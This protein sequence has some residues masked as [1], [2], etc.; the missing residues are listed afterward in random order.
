MIPAPT[1]S[2]LDRH[3][4]LE[5]FFALDPP[6]DGGHYELIDGVL[7]MVPPPG[8]SHGLVVSRLNIVFAQYATRHPDRCLLLVPRAPVWTLA[9]TYLEPDLF[10]VTCERAV[11]VVEERLESAD[12]VVEVLSPS[13]AT[14]DRTAKADAYRTLDVRELW[15]VDM[16][17]QSVEQRV[18][19]ELGWRVAG[20]HRGEAPFEAAVFPEL[21]VVPSA[22]FGPL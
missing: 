7:Y 20:V 21:T 13:T 8:W 1:A 16:E 9:G 10:L 15:L 18:P 2:S 14:Y 11:R 5:E 4:T 3:C 22:L 19:A 17:A 6:L 12:L